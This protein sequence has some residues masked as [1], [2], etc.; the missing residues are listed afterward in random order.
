VTYA[1][2]IAIPRQDREQFTM[3]L[4]QGLEVDVDKDPNQRLLNV[5]AQQRARWLLENIDEFIL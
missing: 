2:V 3:L 1:E 5:I 4:E